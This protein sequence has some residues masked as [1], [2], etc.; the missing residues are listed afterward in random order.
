ML[1]FFNRK[2]VIKSRIN[3]NNN[4]AT[5][6]L[7]FFLQNKLPLNFKS[8][9]TVKRKDA[10]SGMTL[11]NYFQAMEKRLENAHTTQNGRRG[12]STAESGSRKHFRENVQYEMSWAQADCSKKELAP[13][14]YVRGGRDRETEYFYQQ[15]PDSRYNKDS[16]YLPLDDR[17]VVIP[18]NWT[19]ERKNRVWEQS[20]VNV[21]RRTTGAKS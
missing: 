18:R 6:A 3:L 1:L 10:S 15:R 20:K 11:E 13:L 19:K 21:F 12:V 16:L 14:K 8:K 7:N 5:T 2:A 9:L 17:R 4:K